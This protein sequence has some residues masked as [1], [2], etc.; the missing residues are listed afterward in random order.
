MSHSGQLLGHQEAVWQF[1]F[2]VNFL[3]K[4]TWCFLV[5]LSK[6]AMKKAPFAFDFLNVFTG[7]GSV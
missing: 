7:L 6:D 4:V 3:Y 5:L 1:A 2:S